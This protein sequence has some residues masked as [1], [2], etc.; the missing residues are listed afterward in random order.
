M[1]ERSKD[2]DIALLLKQDAAAFARLVERHQGIV[3]GLAQ[4]AGLKGAD[5]DDAAAEAFAEVYRSLPRFEARSALSTWVHRIACRS[6]WRLATELK[7][8]RP[9]PLVGDR[10]DPTARTPDLVITE[11]RENE[12]VWES[13]A[14]LEPR[15]AS[16]IELH[17][18]R[19]LSVEEV[20]AILECPVGTVK[21]LLYRGREELKRRLARRGL[22]P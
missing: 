16:A 7:R 18:R 13:V 6:I 21:T 20:A 1:I 17:Y 10:A 3:L 14:E 19:E 9:R 22:G 5:L 4:A 12:L 11:T 8:E 2:P 15:Q